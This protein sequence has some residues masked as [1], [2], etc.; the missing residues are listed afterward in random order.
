MAGDDLLVDTHGVLVPEGG[1]PDQHLVD[2]DPQRPPVDGHAVALVSD[3]LG[4]QVLGGP[5]EGVGDPFA[6][7]VGADF[8]A[9]ARGAPR[10]SWGEVLG[11]AEVDEFEVPVGV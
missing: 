10:G 11:E 5:A 8:A 3:H 6:V 4:S 1:L 9:S 2:Q 7:A